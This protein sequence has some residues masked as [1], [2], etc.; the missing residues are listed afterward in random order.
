MGPAESYWAHDLARWAIPDEILAAAPVPPWGFPPEFFR[1]PSEPDD[2]PS[3]ARA[4]EAL[5]EGGSVL[6][7][8]SGGGAAG[9]ALVPPAGELI[10]VDETPSMLAMVREAAAG[11]D[12]AG[13]PV[14]LT[15]IEGRWP[16]VASQVPTA[17]VVVCHH[18]FYNVSDLGAF[19]TE[20]GEH[21]KERV[22]VE[23]T[24]RHPMASLN[25]LWLHFHGIQR[26][27]GPGADEA[28]EVLAEVGIDASAEHFSRPPRWQGRDRALQVAFARQRLC[29]GPE[30]DPE[31]ESLLSPGADLLSTRAACVWWD[32]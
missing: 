23:L 2:S 27:V 1:A 30:A 22:V 31:I 26:P 19:A 3:R 14:K 6:D 13:H 15:T 9:L 8:G 24:S 20:L 7:V 29:L 4:L 18:V 21:A 28:L 10:A 17:D 25:E 11:L 16:D 5:P 32:P 12:A